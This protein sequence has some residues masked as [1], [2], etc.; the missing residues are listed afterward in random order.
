MTEPF[1]APFTVMVPAGWKLGSLGQGV[2]LL[3]G[4]PGND[5]PWLY[6]GLPENVFADPCDSRDGPLDPPVSTTVDGIVG[7]LGQMV[8][9]KAGPITDVVVGPHTG[10]AFEL[11]NTIDTDSAECY[12]VMWLPMWTNMGGEEAATIGGW[13]EQ[14]WVLDVEGMPVIVDRGGQAVDAVAT[15][16]EFGTPVA[17]SPAASPVATPSAPHLTYV[18]LGDSL[19]FAAEED[20]DGCTSAAVIYGQQ[21]QDALGMPVEVHNLTM[22]NSLDSRGL[23]RYLENGAKIG[24]VAEDVFR[25]VA[26]ADIVSV[27][28]GFNDFGGPAPAS[29]V[30]SFAANLDAILGR[31]DALREGKPT[32]VLVTQIY[33]NGGTEWTP[34][35]EAQNEVICDLAAKHEATCVDIYHAFNGPDGSGSPVA[36]GYL[37]ADQTHPSQR[38]MEVIADALTRGT[39]R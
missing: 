9:F 12:G 32:T 3:D 34:L 20:C 17:L 35:V 33:N 30:T 28:I 23:R 13:R 26:S 5:A 19:L 10:K 22:H 37:G 39:P 27:T 6:I 2:V 14:M 29:A 4:P 11:T 24:R 16:L 18:A 21:L 7:A 38:G 25:A 15:T 8:G 36:L 1:A 31:I